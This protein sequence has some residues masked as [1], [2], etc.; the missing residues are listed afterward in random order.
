MNVYKKSDIEKYMQRVLGKICYE[1]LQ[2]GVIFE[3]QYESFGSEFWKENITAIKDVL[4]KKT[5]RNL[6]YTYDSERIYMFAIYDVDRYEEEE[7]LKELAD[8]YDNK[9]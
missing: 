6:W 1:L 2:N 5:G 7:A 3:D 9:Y 8:Y 4:K